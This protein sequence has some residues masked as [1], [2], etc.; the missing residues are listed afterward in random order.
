MKKIAIFD[1]LSIGSTIFKIIDKKN[2]FNVTLLSARN[3]Y[4]LICKQI[5]KY[6]PRY[7]IITN[8]SVYK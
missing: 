2:F 7:F 3:N 5:N 1:Q 6:K 4:N 8:P